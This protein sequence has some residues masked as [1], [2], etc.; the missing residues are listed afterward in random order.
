MKPEYKEGPEAAANFERVMRELFTVPKP[1]VHRQQKS[2]WA[3]VN[4]E[5]HGP[6]A[7]RTKKSK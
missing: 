3:E 4:E 2:V 6:K 7:K 5:L 1:P